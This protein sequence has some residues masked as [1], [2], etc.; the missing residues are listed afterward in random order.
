MGLL[1]LAVVSISYQLFAKRFCLLCLGIMG[2]L[3]VNSIL[4]FPVKGIPTS[5]SLDVGLYF[6]MV[7][8]FICVNIMQVQ[9]NE[10]S[11]RE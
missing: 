8:F 10:L 11:Q 4:A 1:L 3:V 2:I 9:S 5:F 6:L 7:V